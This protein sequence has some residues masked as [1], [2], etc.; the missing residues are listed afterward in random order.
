MA[1]TNLAQTENTPPAI[2]TSAEEAVARFER[3]L[4]DWLDTPFVS[5]MA[6]AEAGTA[7]MITAATHRQNVDPDTGEVQSQYAYLVKLQEPVEYRKQTGEIVSLAA[8]DRAIVAF[9][10]VGPIRKARFDEYSTILTDH[11]PIANMKLQKRSPSAK[12]AA[13]NKGPSADFVHAS[14]WQAW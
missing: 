4:S 7:V 8:G 5:P 10:A 11:G 6:L 12:A 14:A 3:N 13:N 9:D 2:L 1:K